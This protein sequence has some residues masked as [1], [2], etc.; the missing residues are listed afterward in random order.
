M[1]HWDPDSAPFIVGDTVYDAFSLGRQ[2]HK[3]LDEHYHPK[4]RPGSIDEHYDLEDRPRVLRRAEKVKE[5]LIEF[6]LLHKEARNLILSSMDEGSRTILDE[7]ILQ[8]DGYIEFIR[9]LILAFDKFC[10]ED[11]DDP[12]EAFFMAG[13]IGARDPAQAAAMDNLADMLEDWAEEYKRLES[14]LGDSEDRR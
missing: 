3:S 1:A 8:G 4:D 14:R 2:L 12:T 7:L 5:S 6:Y 11:E 9:T 13:F 10:T